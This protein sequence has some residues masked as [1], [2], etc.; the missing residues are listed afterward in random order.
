MR[1]FGRKQAPIKQM[2]KRPRFVIWTLAWLTFAVATAFSSDLQINSLSAYDGQ[3]NIV[4]QATGNV[5]INGGLLTPPVLPP[6]VANGRLEIQSGRNII[7]ASGTS[8]VAGPGWSVYF[9]SRNAIVLESGSKIEADAGKVTLEASSVNQDGV[10]QADS[11]GTASGLIAIQASTSIKLGADSTISA[12]G[13]GQG[14]S[15]GGTVVIKS[16][17][18]FSDQAGSTIDI[19]GGGQGGNGGK[20]EISAPQIGAIN[21]TVNGQALDGFAGG[22]VTIDPANV[23]LTANG[24][25]KNG[26]TSIAFSSFSGTSISVTADQNI[27]IGGLWTLANSSSS[28]L[29]TLIAGNNISFDNSAGI[30]AGAKWGVDLTAG[31]ALPQGS[32]PTSGNDGIYLNGTAYLQTFDGSINLSASNEVIVGSGAIRTIGGGSIGVTTTYGNINSGTSVAGY[33][34]YALG[35]GTVAKPYYTPFQFSGSGAGQTINYNQSNLGGIATAAGGNVTLNAGSNVLSFPATTVAAGDA[36][37]GAFG[38]EAGNVSITAGGNVYGNFMLANGTGTV[39]AGQNAGTLQN[40]VALSLVA[41]SWNLN[42]QNN[43]YLQEVRNPNGVF[44]NTT[45]GLNHTVSTGNHLFDYSPSASVSLKAANGVYLTGYDLPRPNGA[46]PM[47]LPATLNINAGAGGSTL[48]TPA[49]VDANG[50]SVTLSDSDI[51]LFPSANGNLHITTTGGGGLS[52]GNFDGSVAKLLMSNS[53]QKQWFIANSGVQPFSEE[54]NAITPP[55]LGNENPVILNISGSMND[56]VLQ[57]SKLA[58]VTVDG[59]MNNC[60][61]FGQNSNAGDTTSISVGGQIYNSGSFNQ[62]TLAQSFPS[63]PA[64]DLPPGTTNSWDIALQLAVNPALLPTQSL[65]GLPPS[66]LASYLVSAA[67]FP[68]VNFGSFLA[69]DP[70]SGTLTAIGPLSSQ[71]LTALESPTLTVARY[72]SN[73]YPLLDANG[74]FVTDTISWILTASANAALISYLGAISQEASP[75][76]VNN[77][78]YVVGGTGEFDVTANSINLGNSDGILTVGNGSILGRD[79]SLLAPYMTSGSGANLKVTVTQDQ[80]ATVDGVTTTTSSLTIPSSTIATLGGGNVTVNSLA[81]T[82]DLGSQ[83]LLPFE[84]EIMNNNGQI[85]LGIYTSG[86]GNMTVTAFGTINIDGS[87]VATLDGGNVF[88]QSLTGGVN[89]GSGGTIAIPINVFSPTFSFPY[90]PAEHVFA[91]G[92]VAFT[93]APLA[94]GSLVP[95]AA[96]IPGNITVLTP[97]GSIYT[98]S[99]GILQENLSGGGLSAAST[100]TLVAGSPGYM[101]NIM[102]GQSGVIGGTIN[103]TASGTITGISFSPLQVMTSDLSPGYAGVAYS[104]QLSATNGLAPYTWS[105]VNGSLPSGLTLAAGGLISGTPAT[106]GTFNFTVQAGDAVSEIATQPLSLQIAPPA[107]APALSAYGYTANGF[108]FTLTGTTNA[109]YVVEASTNLVNWVPLL[110]NNAPFVFVDSNAAQYSLRFYQAVPLP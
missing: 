90:E 59:D 41:G 12:Q 15:A 47:L 64:N 6:G 33:N 24:A 1:T 110:T 2:K 53:G 93:L 81:G 75:L 91:D 82:M 60:S 109:A 76:G 3:S 55:E 65:Q 35:T 84:A 18:S 68:G 5:V 27:E 96:T 17:A 23:Y 71:I 42:A 4:F 70:P 73:G 69:C 103:L 58:Q 74:H 86:G 11:I 21:S 48:D 40:N 66:T 44:N 36:G 101:G 13:D 50:N 95:G 85:G 38:P 28:A 92:I 16:D 94:G 8:I 106:N 39:T 54:D 79:Y 51:T 88:I 30:S 87:R 10:I 32:T 78:A 57:V 83:S 31:T 52:S 72:A 25:A 49:A 89:A 62:V 43:I 26:Y 37:I 107:S 77:G 80:T 97:E 100:I 105:L 34:Y 29:L 63:L 56:L 61:F 22:E 104:Q 99:G 67:A 46:V 108:S 9:T 20:A 45:V 14:I 7:V 102:L 98:T 19:A